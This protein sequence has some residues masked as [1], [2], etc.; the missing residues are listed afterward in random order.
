MTAEI[1]Y[2]ALVVRLVPACAFSD[3]TIATTRHPF[4]CCKG[5]ALCGRTTSSPTI[6]ETP[7][8]LLPV[9]RQSGGPFSHASASLIASKLGSLPVQTRCA[10]IPWYNNKRPPGTVRAPSA[11]AHRI[12]VVSLPAR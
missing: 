8:R 1:E 2:P 4:S 7:A 11:R 5:T 6:P 9:L 12:R 10:W 3:S